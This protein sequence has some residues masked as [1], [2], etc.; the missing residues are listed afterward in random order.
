MPCDLTI[1]PRYFCIFRLLQIYNTHTPLMQTRYLVEMCGVLLSFSLEVWQEWKH[2]IQFAI[3][4]EFV[5]SYH[6]LSITNTSDEKKWFLCLSWFFE[7]IPMAIM[8][9]INIIQLQIAD[10]KLKNRI[11]DFWRN[12]CG[13]LN[14]HRF[15]ARFSIWN[16]CE[17]I[18]APSK[19]FWAQL[20][21]SAFS[22]RHCKNSVAF[23]WYSC[24]YYAI[25]ALKTNKKK[26]I[27]WKTFLRSS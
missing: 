10:L 11:G 22:W 16:F 12:Q 19:Q 15:R 24:K 3:E 6:R 18:F 26:M 20:S 13:Q 4:R 14:C 17:F 27:T 5:F 21:R 23:Q 1:V 8:N 25:A 7:L 2:R 9:K